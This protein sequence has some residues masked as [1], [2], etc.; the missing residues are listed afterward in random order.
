ML[1]WADPFD[2]YGTSTAFALQNGYTNF[3]VTFTTARTGAQAINTNGNSSILR[4]LSVPSNVLG[5]GVGMRV[6]SYGTTGSTGTGLRWQSAGNVLELNV[7]PMTDNSIGVWDRTGTLK[8]ITAPNLI[9]PGSYQW[10]EAKAIGNV[11]GVNTGSV[12]VRLNGETEVIV[13][14]INLPN[15]FAYH[16]VGSQTNG[17]SNV[18]WDDYIVWDNSGIKNNDFMGDRRLVCSFTSANGVPQDFIPSAGAAWDCLNNS[19]PVDTTYVE[20][21]TAGNVSQF[22]KTALGIASNDIAA[23]VISGRL[24]K[25]DAGIA[26]GRVGITSNGNTINSPELFPGTTGA[27]FNFI[28]ELD[29]NGNIPWL[30]PAYDAAQPRI[31]RVQ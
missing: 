16:Q 12:E 28:Q 20:G 17:T 25:T 19:P 3:N 8:G 27:F 2:Q 24:F 11:A 14:G 26:S 1:V 9:I 30:Q 31:T 21:S 18:S 22:Q 5:Q 7:T 23:V 4:P 29:P 15:I 13:N 10:L 6:N